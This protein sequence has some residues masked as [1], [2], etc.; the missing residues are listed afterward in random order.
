MVSPLARVMRTAIMKTAFPMSHANT[1]RHTT[2]RHA[3]IENRLNPRVHSPANTKLSTAFSLSAPC[4]EAEI[5][6]YTTSTPSRIWNIRCAFCSGISLPHSTASFVPAGA[7]CRADAC[8]ERKL[9]WSYPRSRN[10][11]ITPQSTA[12]AAPAIP[13]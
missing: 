4:P 11:A 9:A 8:P 1:A 2:A 13:A 6:R 3:V 5:I 10:Q 12:K 7:P